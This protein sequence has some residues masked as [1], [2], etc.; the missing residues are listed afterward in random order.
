MK[1]LILTNLK[2]W[3]GVS[4]TLDA[5]YSSIKIRDGKIFELGNVRDDTDAIDMKGVYVIPGLIDAHVHMCLDPQIKDPFAHGK[6]EK[7]TLIKQMIERAQSMLAAG[8]TT[9]R[10]LGG[11]KW[12]ELQVRDLIN[13]GE[14]QGCRL[15]CSGQPITSVKGHCHHWG[16]EAADVEQALSVLDRQDKRG[17]DLIKVMATGGSITPDSAPRDSQFTGEVLKAIV[18][19]ANEL[20]YRVAAHCHGTEGIRNAAEAGVTTIEHCSWVGD[21]GWGKSYDPEAV[22]EIVSN[23]VWVSPTINA[24]WKRYM[25]TKQFEG[26]VRENY[27]K[28]KKAGV[29]LIASTDAGIPGVIHHHLPLAVPVFA[30]FAELSPVQALRSATSDCAEA[31]GLGEVVGQIKAGYTADLVFFDADPTTNLDVLANPV[32]VMSRGAFFQAR[33]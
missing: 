11:G 22:A 4:E 16:G 21:E 27:S 18:T 14:V 3:D 19:R 15:I 9:A 2:L 31:I 13:Q 32:R 17:V 12:L 20:N 29:K 10:D 7:E 25:G 23:E 26:M 5:E 24:G 6:I 30:H 28:M 1:D 8:I 33:N